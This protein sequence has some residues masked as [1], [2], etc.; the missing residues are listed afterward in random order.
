MLFGVFLQKFF[1]LEREGERDQTYTFNSYL[2]YKFHDRKMLWN[3]LESNCH[4]GSF[5]P[6]N[7]PIEGKKDLLQNPVK[8]LIE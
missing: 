8:K 1:C 3:G 4:T 7:N 2:E 6:P 5:F